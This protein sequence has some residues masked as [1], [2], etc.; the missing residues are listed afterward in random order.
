MEREKKSSTAPALALLPVAAG[1]RLRSLCTDVVDEINEVESRQMWFRAYL[2]WVCWK[3]ILSVFVQR[4]LCSTTQLHAWIVAAR[5]L[6]WLRRKSGRKK[7]LYMVCHLHAR[8]DQKDENSDHK[9][10]KADKRSRTGLV[11]QHKCIGLFF[12]DSR[13]EL[14]STESFFCPVFISK[15]PPKTAEF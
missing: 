15:T 2:T 11:V 8:T 10:S 7:K 3:K 12:L 6:S 1:P 4:N 9:E 5:G 13:Q 14:N